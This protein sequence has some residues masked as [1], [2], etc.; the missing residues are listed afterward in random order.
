MEYILEEI[1]DLKSVWSSINDL[2]EA[3]ELLNNLSWSEVHTRTLRRQLDDLLTSSRALPAN[4]RQYSAF[5]KIQNLVKGHIKNFGLV[6][7]LKGDAMKPRHWNLL[8]NELGIRDLSYELLSLRDVWSLNFELN[9][10]TIRAITTQAINEQI[11]ATNLNK[12]EEEWSSITLE[13]FN[14]EDKCRLVKNWD[15]LLD[16]CKNDVNTL[17]TMKNSPYYPTFEQD[18]STMESKLNR[19]SLLLDVWLEVQRQ[20]VYL[21]GVFGNRANDIKSLL[22]IESTRFS[23]LSY[24]LHNVLKRIYR[25]QTA[26][27]VL[28]I[29]D[30][31][32]VFDKF[33]ESLIKVRKSL[34]DYLE[35]QRELFPRFYFVGNEDLLDII[36]SSGDITRI[37]RHLKKMFAGISKIEVN[38]EN[39]TIVAVFSEEGEKVHMKHPVSLLKSTRLHELLRE[40][41]IEVKLAYIGSSY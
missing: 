23:N 7:E 41:E 22:P 9:Q 40:L 21:D 35:K 29:T 11:I 27:D 3:L 12:I 39:S 25:F 8:F 15:V 19:F 6:N 5:S 37:N 18:I 24:E 26:L 2:W 28:L 4:V 34:A 30:I 1:S 14:Y 31:Q 36:G 10:A 13:V 16:Q 17:A 33:H 38:K 32:S 20:W